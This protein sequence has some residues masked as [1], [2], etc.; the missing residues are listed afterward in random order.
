MK[1]KDLDYKIPRELIALFPKKPRDQSEL[2]I[3]DKVFR[4]IKFY[5]LINE[6]RPKDILV[7]NNTKVIKAYF[8]GL[9]NGKKISIN[10]N[11]LEDKKKNIW[12]SFVKTNKKIK[13]NDE[14]FFFES[15]RAIVHSIK[16]EKNQVSILLKF[17]VSF[18]KL[19][20]IIE[21]FGG[22]PVPPYIQKRGSMKSDFKDYQSIF[23][24]K[25]GA[26]AAPTAS[27]HFTDK[28]IKDL[29]KKKVK[30]IEITLHVNGGTFL[31]IKTENVLEHNMHFENGAISNKSANII[32]K[33]KKEGGRI[34]AV[35]TTV[36]RLL[37]SAKDSNGFI[38]P[39]NGQT[40]IFIK[41]GYNINTI[42]GLITNFHTPKSTL[43]L[44]VF[45]ILGKEKTKSL[46]KF[47]IKQKLRFFSYGDACL[48]WNNNAKI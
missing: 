19:N 39:F 5:E 42:D 4:K 12:S 35:G 10:L 13:K 28:L 31:P 37:E 16:I 33:T 34:I 18:T 9:L 38:K 15:L 40:N 20:E 21:I 32:N 26:V 6:L 25:Q 30:M 8:S 14:I 2:V 43:L 17:N 11:K 1:I 7:F 46:Y 27:L 23:A 45:S 24:K 44:L 47:A 3:V 36:L 29:K 22:M 48:I 41:P